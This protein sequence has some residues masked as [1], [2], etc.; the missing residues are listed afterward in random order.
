MTNDFQPAATIDVLQKRALIIRRIRDFF[1]SRGYFHVETPAISRDIV[2]DRYLE[3]IRVNN[4]GLLP[5]E[6]A[7]TL[8]LQTSPEFAMKRIVAAGAKAIY[9]IGPV[10]RGEEN[11]TLH[12]PEFTMLEWYKTGQTTEEAIE[13][14][15]ELVEAAIGRTG[16]QGRSYGSVFEEIAQLDPHRAAIEEL[17]EAANRLGINFEETGNEDRDHW[18]N[19]ILT[20]SIEPGLGIP[21]PEI[22]YD[23][24]ASQS[25]LARLK[26]EPQVAD[27]FELYIDGVELANG[28]NE[29]LDA[30]ILERRNE[31]NNRLRKMDGREELPSIS[32]LLEA[33]RSGM[34][35]CCGVALGVDRLVM[36]GLGLSSIDQAMAFPISRA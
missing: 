26:G 28:Y 29:L 13:M 30:G 17:K 1:E 34:P 16:T 22:I 18:L 19:L 35:Q 15:G 9:Q 11:G 7:S 31:E 2:V 24:P 12:N 4:S 36:V 21:A 8:F 25:A 32:R 23:W 10:F 20:H 3:P 14:I 5:A 33:M 6:A 27:R